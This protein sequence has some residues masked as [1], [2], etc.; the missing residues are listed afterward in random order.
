MITYSLRGEPVARQ[1]VS[2]M[3]DEARLMSEV[4]ERLIE[5]EAEKKGRGG[6]LVRRLAT[7]ADL[8]P[9]AFRTVL[10]VGCG[11]VHAVVAS[12]EEQA[13]NRGLTRQ[14]LHWQWSQDMRAIRQVFPA[15][16]GMLQDL[17]DSVAHHE[18]TVSPADALRSSTDR[19][20]GGET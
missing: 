13:R 5:I 9:S 18:D 14:A 6:A 10:H 8:S 1:G 2:A 4:F 11:Q 15:L 12:Y 17:R 16:A 7:I 20:N 3:S 19:D